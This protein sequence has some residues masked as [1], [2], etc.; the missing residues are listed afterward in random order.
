M[1]SVIRHL[2]KYYQFQ[3]FG[4]YNALLSL[5]KITAEEIKGEYNG[6]P[7][8]GL[9]YFVLNDKGEKASNPFK[10]SLF[11]KSA[12]LAQLES[13][14]GQSRIKL[15][16]NPARES[17]RDRIES[18]MQNALNETE[19]KK[20]LLEEGINAVVRRNDNG[21]IYGI[22]FIDHNSKTVFNGSELGKNLS[23]NVFNDWWNNGNKAELSKKE[24]TVSQKITPAENQI[25]EPQN[26]SDFLAKEDTPYS[27]QDNNIFEA[28]G[29]LLP[30]AQ[31]EDF[32]E[33]AFA[34]QM[35]RKDKR[36]KPRL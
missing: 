27:G 26:Q 28:F 12:G 34:N 3:T 32:Q 7:K 24:E 25:S 1:A 11:G 30:Q 16:N 35:K 2:P 5:F 6:I 14:Y 17:V 10:A 29:N 9:V 20:K 36:R 22:T 4:A 15:K 31:G 13:H 8:Q 19:F 23:A 33:T 21:R 18:V